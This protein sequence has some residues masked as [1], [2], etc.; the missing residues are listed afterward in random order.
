MARDFEVAYPVGEA[1]ASAEFNKLYDVA[2]NKLIAFMGYIGDQ[3]QETAFCC[4]FAGHGRRL[5]R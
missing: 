1:K 2:E 5:V 3:N 4:L